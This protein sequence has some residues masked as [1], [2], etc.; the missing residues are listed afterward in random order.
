MPQHFQLNNYMFVSYLQLHG[1]KDRQTDDPPG[2]LDDKNWLKE[3]AWGG[4]KEL[5]RL[6]RMTKGKERQKIQ[7]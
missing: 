3:V 7:S 1:R 6:L 2:R 5:P 4:W